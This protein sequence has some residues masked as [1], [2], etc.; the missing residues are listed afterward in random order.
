MLNKRTNKQREGREGRLK[1]RRGGEEGG[2]EKRE[3]ECK[4]A[5]PPQRRQWVIL[6]F[7]KFPG[8]DL[9]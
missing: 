7:I 9:S 5:F 1:G 8:N 3:G 6:I 2:E 4:H